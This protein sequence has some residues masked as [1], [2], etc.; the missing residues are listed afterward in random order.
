[1]NLSFL[2]DSKNFCNLFSVS[3]EIFVLHGYDWIHW[4]VKSCTPTAHRWL[5]RDSQ[6]SLSTLW[7]AAIESPKFYARSSSANASS[8]RGPCNFGPLADL[9]ISVFREVS[10]NTVFTQIRTSQRLKR[11]SMRRTCVWVSAFRNSV[12]HKIFSEFLQPLRCVGIRASPCLLVIL[13]FSWFWGFR[14]VHVTTQ[15]IFQKCTGLPVLVNPHF[16]LTRL[17]DGDLNDQFP[18][19]KESWVL[20]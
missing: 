5:F 8:P 14:L 3:R 9:A 15:L 6:P 2:L 12:I 13:I 20:M 11:W 10:I 4:V 16:H 17:L 1:M 19:L 18:D 7:S